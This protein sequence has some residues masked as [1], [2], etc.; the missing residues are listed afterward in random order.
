MQQRVM[1]LHYDSANL[2][3][4]GEGFVDDQTNEEIDALEGEATPA[5]DALA[6]LFLLMPCCTVEGGRSSS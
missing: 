1:P 2:W 6:L 5:T 3:V 4:V